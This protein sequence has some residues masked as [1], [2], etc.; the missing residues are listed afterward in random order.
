MKDDLAEAHAVLRACALFSHLEP[1]VRDKIVARARVRLF[2]ARETIFSAGA[3][4]DSLMAVVR[5]EVHITALSAGGKE[6][7]LAILHAG[8]VF[9]EIALLDGKERSAD[10][11]T[12]T[13]CQIAVIDRADVLQLLDQHPRAW[14][15]FVEVLCERLRRTDDHLVEIAL[16]DL[17]GRLARALLRVA[18]ADRVIHLP[19]HDLGKMIGASRERVNSRLQEWHRAGILK[20]G[21]GSIA[22][23]DEKAL[24]NSTR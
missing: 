9:G 24:L 23:L 11:R 4:H 21:K 16:L 5:G 8:E 17:P 12:V 1:D 7:V 20:V 13:A 15:G 22:L 18:D 3:P 14:R 6:V 2:G 19:Q 10:A